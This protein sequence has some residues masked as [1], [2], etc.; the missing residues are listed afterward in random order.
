M[1]AFN[2]EDEA[3]KI[4]AVVF[5]EA[6]A[7]FGGQVVND[8]LVLVRG[9]YERD[10]DTGRMVVAE[11]IPLD[12]VRERAIREVEIRLPAKNFGRDGMRRLA[13]VLEGHPGDRRVSFVVEVNGSGPALRVRASTA[14]RIRPSDSVV[15]A[16]EAVCGRGAV[17]LK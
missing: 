17:S 13:E 16:I 12:V 11:I 6:F 14:R 9:K 7:K 1:A 8:A 3:A 2:L 5:P 15:R 10:D 4:E